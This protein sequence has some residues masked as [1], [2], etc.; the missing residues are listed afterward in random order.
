MSRYSIITITYPDNSRAQIDCNDSITQALFSENHFRSTLPYNEAQLLDQGLA[1]GKYLDPYDFWCRLGIRAGWSPNIFFDEKTYL[2]NNPEVRAMVKGYTL[3]PDANPSNLL[4][5]SGLQYWLIKGR[6]EIVNGERTVDSAPSI[7]TFTIGNDNLLAI[8]FLG[9]TFI[10][11]DQTVQAGDI[12]DGGTAT[13]SSLTLTLNGN[14]GAATITNI[15]T[16]NVTARAAT[17]VVVDATNYSGVTNLNSMGSVGQVTIAGLS[18]NPTLGID[19]NSNIAVNY[20]DTILSGNNKIINLNVINNVT[21][22][23]ITLNNA[24]SGYFAT[25]AIESNGATANTINWLTGTAVTG[26]SALNITGM[27][28]LTVSLSASTNTIRAVTAI[29]QSSVTFADNITGTSGNI[30]TAT[31]STVGSSIRFTGTQ[32]L[33][34]TNVLTFTGT[35]NSLSLTPTTVAAITNNIG[36]SFTNLDTLDI[37]GQLISN[38]AVSNFGSAI[39]IVNINGTSLAPA[40]TLGAATISGLPTGSMV[41]LGMASTPITQLNGVLTL[42]GTGAVMV[43][44]LGTTPQAAVVDNIAI[45]TFTKATLNINNLAVPT[46][47]NNIAFA[48]Q[49][50]ALTTLNVT[51][52]NILAS[53]VTVTLS[54]TTS[55]VRTVVATS[56]AIVSFTD[57]TTGTTSNLLTATFSAAGSTIKFTNTQ[58]LAT[59]NV[60]KF[61]GIGNTLSLT[62]ATIA[63]SGSIG[64]S[65]VNLNILDVNGQLPNTATVTVTNYG[66]SINTVN[67]GGTST[68]PAPTLGTATIAALIAGSTINLGTSSNAIT[69]LGGALTMNGAVGAVTVNVLGT[70]P[71]AAVS[72]ALV[73]GTFTNATINLSS[74]AIPTSTN[75]IGFV[76]TS[77]SVTTLNV[78]G[79]NAASYAIN[80]GTLPAATTVFYAA[81]CL[82]PITV[83]SSASSTNITGSATAPNILTGGVGNNTILGGTAADIIDA[84]GGTNIVTGHGTGGNTATDINTYQISAPSAAIT[85]ITDFNPGTSSTSVDLIQFNRAITGGVISAYIS[86]SGSLVAAAAEPNLVAWNGVGNLNLS[87]TQN[88]IK[89]TGAATN[90]AGLI[91]AL[92]TKIITT[93]PVATAT[94][95]MP[96][97]YIN[98]DGFVHVALFQ[99]GATASSTSNVSSATDIIALAGVT[100][101][102]LIDQEDFANFI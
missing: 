50:A 97:V 75:T 73:F 70:T 66:T 55:L 29:P 26:T 71:V 3:N 79:G 76:I 38:V 41:N 19:S 57:N 45:T 32:S 62:P 77:T 23:T 63:A 72:D 80:F 48:I 15:G 25:I 37:N 91:T 24:C 27:Q 44:L 54:S 89:Y 102:P 21:F 101:L 49:G 28:A 36:A 68:S 99:W 47:A 35:S 56:K 96:V 94:T 95:G 10:G 82:S 85:T 46:V 92:G 5:D 42:S 74:E 87:A 93:A 61:I 6:E 17:G 8:P 51:G 18:L 22:G 12:A 30:L 59:G 16:V 58:T 39:N 81:A 4:Y 9:G 100:A 98:T 14:S 34:T 83:T 31:F 86:G 1:S 7:F 33:A 40:P 90:I 69:Q 13:L 64:A 67:L 2:N 60:L 78:I 52:G 53:A 43:N 65:F 88:I 84:K 20:V 11:T